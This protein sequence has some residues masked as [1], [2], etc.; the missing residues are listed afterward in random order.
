MKKSQSPAMRGTATAKTKK[1]STS[2][3]ESNSN[4][5]VVAAPDVQIA[6]AKKV[7]A[8]IREKEK[9]KKKI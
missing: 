6:H 1:S 8:Q 4:A 2:K 5:M 7:L 3:T 9:L